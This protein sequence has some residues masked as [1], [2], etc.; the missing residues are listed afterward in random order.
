MLIPLFARRPRRDLH[1]APEVLEADEDEVRVQ[2]EAVAQAAAD[3]P[4]EEELL[5]TL[6]AFF[7]FR[8]ANEPVLFATRSAGF[9]CAGPRIR[10]CIVGRGRT[11]L[12][13]MG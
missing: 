9:Q 6:S 10:A 4:A 5:G 8:S 13:G 2:R 11:Q 3:D 7:G 12:W 1:G